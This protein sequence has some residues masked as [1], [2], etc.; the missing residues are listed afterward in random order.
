MNAQQI[1]DRNDKI[2]KSTSINWLARIIALEQYEYWYDP[3][4]KSGH[5]FNQRLSKMSIKALRRIGELLG[6]EK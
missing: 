2:E 5:D 6:L 4:G 3:C 1:K